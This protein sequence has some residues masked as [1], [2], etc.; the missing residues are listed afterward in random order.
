MQFT[1]PVRLALRS[2]P[3][4]LASILVLHRIVAGGPTQASEHPGCSWPTTPAADVPY[5]TDFGTPQNA[6]CAVSDVPFDF[7][8]LDSPPAATIDS[9]IDVVAHWYQGFG[10]ET[11]LASSDWNGWYDWRWNKPDNSGDGVAAPGWDPS[12][13]PLIG[14]YR[15]D[16][17]DVLGWIAYWLASGGVDA[18]SFP[19]AAGFSS[20]WSKDGT[21]SHAYFEETPN[22]KALGYVLPLA[23]KG[24]AAEISR[25]AQELV[26]FVAAHP[27]A[28]TEAV[29]GGRYAVV[30]VWD[31]EALRGNFDN[32]QGS[33]KSTAFLRDLADR[34][35]SIGYDGVTVLARNGGVIAANADSLR[36][37]HVNVYFSSYDGKYAGATTNDGYD[38]YVDSLDTTTAFGRQN[39][40]PGVFTS[41]ET[42]KPH[43]SSY[44]VAGASPESFRRLLRKTVSAID[45]Q[46]LPRMITVYNV[47]EW[48]EGGPGL[49]P[50]AQDGFGYLEALRTT[51]G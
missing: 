38:A 7:G 47:S 22:A 25:R 27:W 10:N 33:A 40:V 34:F 31:L 21:W 17:P 48:A 24:G 15:G 30:N 20:S 26:A 49:I 51:V 6:A 29:D 13:A 19:N 46:G 12:R 35:R 2:L 45:Q 4:V 36:D 42:V 18:V 23:N 1:K 32:Y 9:G 3:V 41:L 37:D 28:H 39:T 43:P 11:S 14:N 44:A 8:R 16:D 5:R 50:N